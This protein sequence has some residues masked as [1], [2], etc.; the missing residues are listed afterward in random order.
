MVV[1][2]LPL[3]LSVACSVSC[4]VAFACR[5]VLLSANELPPLFKSW[6]E[7]DLLRQV[8]RSELVCQCPLQGDGIEERVCGVVGLSIMYAEVR[9]ELDLVSWDV[10]DACLLLQSPSSWMELA[11]VFSYSGLPVYAFNC[12]SVG[13]GCVMRKDYR[14]DAGSVMGHVEEIVGD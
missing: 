2:T 7:L 13:N 5:I 8:V 1:A 14:S 6:Y 10:D 4:E 11:F 9:E 3:W 12:E